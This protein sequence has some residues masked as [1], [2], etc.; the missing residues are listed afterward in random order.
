VEAGQLRRPGKQFI[1]EGNGRS[2]GN[3]V[4]VASNMASLAAD[5]HARR[6]IGLGQGLPAPNR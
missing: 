2:H 5:F 1:I 6:E 3:V 4:S